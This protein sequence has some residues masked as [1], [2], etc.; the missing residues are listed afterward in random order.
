[1]VPRPA[2][3]ST[4]NS[5]EKQIFLFP[6]PRPIKSETLSYP[7]PHTTAHQGIPMLVPESLPQK[8][9]ISHTLDLDTFLFRKFHLNL[10]IDLLK[11]F[12]EICQIPD[13][14][15]IIFYCH[16]LKSWLCYVSKQ[17]FL[18]CHISCLYSQT[19]PTRKCHLN[20][21]Y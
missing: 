3:A 16:T 5:L 12:R 14:F 13:F 7:P 2:A 9:K 11:K 4:G 6:P 1:M 19:W 17:F 21:L 8:I 20:P 15:P 10:V 18:H